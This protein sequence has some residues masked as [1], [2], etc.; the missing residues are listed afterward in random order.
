[1][2]DSRQGG[3]RPADQEVTPQN[4]GY[5]QARVVGARATRL[6]AADAGR[7]CSAHRAPAGD[8]LGRLGPEEEGRQVKTHHGGQ[9]SG[10]V[11]AKGG[12]STS[13]G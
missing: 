6:R 5:G 12:L 11:H 13:S 1:M 8:P 3:P 7:P 10:T 9:E 4:T 2:E